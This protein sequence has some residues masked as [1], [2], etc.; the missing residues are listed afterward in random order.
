LDEF[1]E[2]S[3]ATQAKLLRAIEAREVI[4][5]GQSQ[6]VPV[7]VR[8]V[9]A[10]QQP[11]TRAVAEQRLRP[12]LFARL[13][14]LTARLPPLR[15]RREDVPGLFFHF[16][17]EL[18]GGRPPAV[19]SRLLERLCLYDWPFN[20][21][22]LEQLARKLL[23]LHGHESVLRSSNLPDRLRHLGDPGASA[24]PQPDV[25]PRDRDAEDL[26]AL[27]DALRSASGNVARA[28]AAI[29]ISRQRAYRLMNR[30]AGLDLQALRKEVL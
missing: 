16:L 30:A 7:D 2:L 21:R 8:L 28:S 25:S 5:L 17:R 1:V 13:D 22:E 4:P 10:A 6:P 19:E 15:D 29:G 23:V 24:P 9:V 27:V 12:D 26:K 11:L 20:V 3:L 14:G 18:S